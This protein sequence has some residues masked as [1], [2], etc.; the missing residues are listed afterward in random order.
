MLYVYIY[1]SKNFNDNNKT[2]PC[3]PRSR[4]VRFERER[5]TVRLLQLACK[6]SRTPSITLVS[7]LAVTNKIAK[8][9]F[10]LLANFHDA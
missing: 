8:L 1:I 9:V 4:G 10:A 6:N 2:C 5:N 7:V 3:A